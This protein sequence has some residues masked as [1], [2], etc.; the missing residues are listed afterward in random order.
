VI[1]ISGVL[2]AVIAALCYVFFDTLGEKDAVFSVVIV[3]MIVV[4]GAIVCEVIRRYRKGELNLEGL[5]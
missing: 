2:L 5:R 1:G 4:C 3:V